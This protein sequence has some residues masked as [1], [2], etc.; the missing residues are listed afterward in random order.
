MQ[1]YASMIHSIPPFI[2]PG[3]GRSVTAQAPGPTPVFGARLEENEE[4]Q[5]LRPGRRLQRAAG[6]IR[7]LPQG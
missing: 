2:Q 1:P 7:P 5:Y 4:D 6:A 3:F